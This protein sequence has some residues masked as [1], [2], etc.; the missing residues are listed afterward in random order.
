MKHVSGIKTTA[1]GYRSMLLF[2]YNIG[3]S[4]KL[5]FSFWLCDLCLICGSLLTQILTVGKAGLLV[6]QQQ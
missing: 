4:F 5:Q 1:P 6:L 3:A 2:V